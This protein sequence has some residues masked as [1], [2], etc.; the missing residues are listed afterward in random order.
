[1]PIRRA[2]SLPHTR[3]VTLVDARGCCPTVRITCFPRN[4]PKP[5]P[6]PHPPQPLPNPHNRVPTAPFLEHVFTTEPSSHRRS[7]LAT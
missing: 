6:N 5:S 3:I 2:T 7:R 1:M 4:R